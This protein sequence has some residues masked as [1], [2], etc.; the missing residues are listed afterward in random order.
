MK[1]IIIGAIVLVLIVPA[2]VC[3][4][5]GTTEESRFSIVTVSG[6]DTTDSKK[7]PDFT[8]TTTD[9]KILKLSD[10]KGKGVIVNFW[11]TWCRPCRM[12]IPDMIELQRE[13]ES[14]GF[15][16]IGIAIGDE[17][18]NVK[19]FVRRQ[20]MN[21][22]VAVGTPELAKKYGKFTQ[23]GTI[24]GIPTSFIINTKGEIIGYLVGMC[25]K[26][27]FIKAIK[28]AIAK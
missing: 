4:Q 2:L 20:E 18:E 28:Q 6:V 1:R 13:Y 19:A 21:Y 16:F 22:P 12:E 15:S 8:L 26:A 7:A 3:L 9:G 25:N 5:G 14:Q 27:T 17:E 24:R 23:E 10:Y 11:A